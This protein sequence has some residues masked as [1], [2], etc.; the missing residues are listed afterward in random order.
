MTVQNQSLP[1]RMLLWYLPLVPLVWALKAH[2]RQADAEQLHWILAPTAY[3]VNCVSD[4]RFQSLEGVGWIDPLGDFVIAPACAGVN[5]LILLLVLTTV[6]YLHSFPGRTGKSLWLLCA[7]IY[8][9]GGT[10]VVNAVRILIAI[11][12][13]Q[14]PIYGVWLTPE[15]AHRLMGIFLY[16]S[17]LWLLLSLVG[18]VATTISSPHPGGNTAADLLAGRRAYLAIVFYLGMTLVVPWLNGAYG[19][20]GGQFIEH[21]L[22][23]GSIGLLAA[24]IW[25][26]WQR[27]D[28]GTNRRKRANRSFGGTE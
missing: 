2:Y 13:Y 18:H 7:P 5:F 28:A 25:R 6:L 16:L 27:S 26:W 14:A 21:V 17:A 22:T 8:A 24:L 11:H 23:V 12:L 10:V 1:V 4:R 15:R 3:L 19:R 9:Y 20:F